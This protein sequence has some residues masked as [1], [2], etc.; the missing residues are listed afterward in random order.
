MK[1]LRVTKLKLSNAA[2]N[3]LQRLRLTPADF[4]LVLSLG[5]KLDCADLS[6]RVFEAAQFSPNKRLQKLDGLILV[7]HTRSHEVVAICKDLL[8]VIQR[9]KPH[10]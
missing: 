1:R 4:D 9:S 5:Q 7:I 3:D 2:T 10:D 8:E 6:L